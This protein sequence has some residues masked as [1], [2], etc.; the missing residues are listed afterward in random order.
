MRGDLQTQ[1][2]RA[3]LRRLETP[4]LLKTYKYIILSNT[5]FIFYFNL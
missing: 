1:M 4:F 5:F 3:R 2:N